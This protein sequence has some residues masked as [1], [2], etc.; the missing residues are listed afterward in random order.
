LLWGIA[1]NQPFV[2]GNKRAALVATLTFLELNGHTVE[3]SQDELADLMFEIADGLG[4][5]DV[6]ER[7]RDH[8]RSV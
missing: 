6:A 3:L 4:V 8:L 2:D 1:E 5:G 7:L